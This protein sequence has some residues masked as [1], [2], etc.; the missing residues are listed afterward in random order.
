MK[1][2]TQSKQATKIADK[3]ANQTAISNS[4]NNI[5]NIDSDEGTSIIDMSILAKTDY[6]SIAFYLYTLLTTFADNNSRYATAIVEKL[7]FYSDRTPRTIK[8]WLKFLKE[9]GIIEQKSPDTFIIH[10]GYRDSLEA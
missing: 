8:R 3:T 6:R 10:D 5:V 4:T 1:R 7:A 2:E 9:K